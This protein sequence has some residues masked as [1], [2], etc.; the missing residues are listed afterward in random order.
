MSATNDL[1]YAPRG[2]EAPHLPIHKNQV[3]AFMKM[4]YELN[5][6]S[7]DPSTNIGA[8]LAMGNIP[9]VGGCNNFADGVQKSP[10]REKRP[11]KYFYYEH[12]E[13]NAVYY[14][15]RLGIAT[16]G[17]TMYTMGIPCADCAR[18]VIQAG[19]RS[20]VVHKQFED[21][22]GLRENWTESCKV[23]GA[24]LMEAGVMAHRLDRV[25]GLKTLLNG[26]LIDV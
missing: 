9:L 4:A 17:A 18:A 19:I 10:E 15:A 26:K 5:T 20:I 11:Q 6:L 12:G 2:T 21:A 25:L 24:M 14:C 8:M 16:A 22:C 1:E 23:G 3:A 13:R 7:L